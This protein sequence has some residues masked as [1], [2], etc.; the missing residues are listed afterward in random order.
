[1]FTLFAAVVLKGVLRLRHFVCFSASDVMFCS[2]RCDTAASVRFGASAVIFF[3]CSK[4][5]CWTCLHYIKF[6]RSRA[7]TQVY[8]AQER[9]DLPSPGS[10]SKDGSVNCEQWVLHVSDHAS[11]DTDWERPE[12]CT[13]GKTQ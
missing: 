4:I 3:L 13:D 9:Y 11:L 10:C 7:M 5:N 6:T 2:C 12:V 1:M 8:S